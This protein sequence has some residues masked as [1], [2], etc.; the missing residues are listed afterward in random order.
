MTAETSQNT[1][2]YILPPESNFLKAQSNW[3]HHRHDYLRKIHHIIKD[4]YGIESK[5]WSTLWCCS[6]S[7][8]MCK[9]CK[10]AFAFF[11]FQILPLK[12][13]CNSVQLKFE[14]IWFYDRT[15]YMIK[16]NVSGVLPHKITRKKYK[17][18]LTEVRL[19]PF[20]G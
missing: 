14:N 18:A 3:L 9:V 1:V 2:A 5:S 12:E 19:Y 16:T 6:E 20:S 7:F 17:M 11:F 10:I 15:N 13:R 8:M 4:V